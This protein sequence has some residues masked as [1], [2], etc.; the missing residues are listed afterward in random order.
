MQ[1]AGR[2][3][4]AE[5]P[6][7]ANNQGRVEHEQLIDNAIQEW[8]LRHSYDELFDTLVKADVPCGP[9][10]SIAD[11]TKDPQYQARQV[12]EEVSFGEPPDRVKIPTVIPKLSKT[13]GRTE[14]IGPALG[15]HNDEIYKG[16]L[17]LTEAEL[18]T[19]ESEGV[20]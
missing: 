2:P 17:Q 10:Y 6:R 9:V 7:L 14:W 20:I 15:E 5:D 13:P 18:S 11:I 3:D 1:V 8:T 19:F 12:W 4:L 16:L